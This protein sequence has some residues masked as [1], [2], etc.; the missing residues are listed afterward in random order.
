MCGIQIFVCDGVLAGAIRR[1]NDDAFVQV[2]DVLGSDE[3]RPVVDC[4]TEI[5]SIFGAEGERTPVEDGNATD[6]RFLHFYCHMNLYIIVGC[7]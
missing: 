1:V 2:G 5:L 3:D 4:F 7:S 6:S